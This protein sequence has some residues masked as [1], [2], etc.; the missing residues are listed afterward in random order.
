MKLLHVIA[1]RPNFVKMAPL[2]AA[3]RNLD[4]GGEHIAA[5]PVSVRCQGSRPSRG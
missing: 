3:L 1:T 5:G 4:P 2:I